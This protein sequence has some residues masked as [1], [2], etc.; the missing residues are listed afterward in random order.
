MSTKVRATV[1]GIE[2]IEEFK[3][4][5]RLFK[6]IGDKGEGIVKDYQFFVLG[7]WVGDGATCMVGNTKEGPSFGP[8][9]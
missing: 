9:F 2:K 4:H 6:G 7:H 8:K 5:L 1:V 3:K